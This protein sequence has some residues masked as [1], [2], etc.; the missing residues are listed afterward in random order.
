[1]WTPLDLARNG[2]QLSSR[3]LEPLRA[4]A[5]IPH[6]GHWVR[7]HFLNCTHLGRFPMLACGLPRR[8]ASLLPSRSKSF[9]QV[10]ANVQ[11]PCCLPAGTVV[12]TPNSPI[13]SLVACRMGVQSNYS[14][15]YLVRPTRGGWLHRG[16]RLRVACMPVVPLGSL[17]PCSVAPCLSNHVGRYC[18]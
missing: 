8:F 17:T 12:D 13:T 6:R 18:L 3:K 4:L 1:V 9:L 15:I 2:P 10:L 7:S 16:S 5:A 11:L 14:N